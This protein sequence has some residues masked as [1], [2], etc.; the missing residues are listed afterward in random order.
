MPKPPDTPPNSD[1]DG[2]NEDEKRNTDASAEAGQD[3]RDLA[4]AREEAAG[5]PEFSPEPGADDRSR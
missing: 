1:L 3:T 2:V 5:K 4:L